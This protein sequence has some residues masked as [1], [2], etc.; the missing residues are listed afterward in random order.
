MKQKPWDEAKVGD[1]VVWEHAH[2]DDIRLAIITKLTAT[3]IVFGDGEWIRRDGSQPASSAF[4]SRS[5]PWL[6]TLEELQVQRRR[7]RTQRLAAAF[8]RYDWR[9]VP[10]DMLLEVEKLLSTLK[11][12]PQC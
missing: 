7:Y 10:Y 2:G 1:T 11:E 4:A 8:G 6:P 12:K 9:K 3:R 5:Y